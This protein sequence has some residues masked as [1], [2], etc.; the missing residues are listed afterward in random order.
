MLQEKVNALLGSIG[1]AETTL[2]VGVSGGP[3][4]L[5]LLHL[6]KGL[7]GPHSLMAVHLNHGWRDTAVTDAEFVRQTAVSWGIPCRI[8]TENVPELA[9]QEGWSLE[10]AGRIA[11]YRL[12]ADT[13]REIGA[14]AVA[15]GHNADD[16]VE[17]ILMHILRGAGLRGLAG[18]QAAAPLPGAPDLQLVRP[19][20]TTTRAEIEK[21]CREN[22]L[23]PVRDASN[24]DTTFF[25][26]RVRHNLLPLLADYNPQIRERL[27]QMAESA[28][29]DDVYLQQ[30]TAAA[31][32]D[33]VMAQ[34]E[35]WVTLNRERW[36][37]VANSLKFR[38]LRMAVSG[39]RPSVE[40]NFSSIQK[41][42]DLAERGHSGDQADL[43][44][45]VIM[46]ID[47]AQLHFK[48]AE[49]ALPVHLPQMTD[50]H[51]VPLPVPGV[52][53]LAN[54]WLIAAELAATPSLA[55]IRQNQDPWLAFVGLAEDAALQIRPR[56][57]GERMQ[58]LGLHGRSAKLKEV[59]IDRK[60]PARLRP[61]WPI[62]A[63]GARPLWLV[64]HILDERAR[65]TD[66]AQLVV[67]IRCFRE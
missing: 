16:Q 10:E 65:V 48:L 60:I 30:Q 50:V 49:A 23:E 55:A 1:R 15:V 59:M 5:A 47:P 57:P 18:M 43:P 12:F 33:L 42:F 61:S 41:A 54:G 45:G 20:L 36:T 25:R 8:A 66:A 44:G 51:P 63:Q 26:N 11:R 29:A 40:I 32:A 17:T 9:R 67:K 13:A 46:I 58:P 56:Q 34:G 62:V 39:L 37:A 28:A 7:L 52:V 21:Y 2:V 64:G 24:Q 27:R 4:S 35:N 53:R 3:D 22:G 19:F 31:W 14:A 38:L 6:L